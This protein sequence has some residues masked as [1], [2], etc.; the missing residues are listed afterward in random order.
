VS[1][2][3]T[4]T[5]PADL[6]D[7]HQDRAVASAPVGAVASVD[8]PG[9][10][11]RLL[12]LLHKLIDFG[13]QLAGTLQQ[14]TA[15]SNLADAAAR[16][17]TTDIALILARIARGLR[18]AVTLEAGLISRPLRETQPAA[19]SVRSP[20]LSH[21]AQPSARRARPAADPRLSLLPTAEEIAAEIRRQP[22]GAVIADIC[23][24]LGIL[25]GDPLWWE[26]NLAIM[27]H[28]GN[29]TALLKEMSKR[30][31]FQVDDPYASIVPLMPPGW[32]PLRPPSRVPF[33]EVA[34]TGPP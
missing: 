24:D 13:M 20:R 10:T 2:Q 5:A 31:H 17:G 19:A 1:A 27:E 15:A 29:A 6:P 9:R 12:G 3:P 21:A 22:I 18:L 23:R 30:I 4:S 8:A 16:F 28:G 34:A 33:P 25:S 26:L 14:C 7:P 11:E 32:Q